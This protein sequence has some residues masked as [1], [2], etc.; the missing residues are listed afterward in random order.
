[1]L[2]RL[3][4]SLRLTIALLLGLA[5]ISIAGT[6]VP[7]EANRFEPFFQTP[8]YRLLLILLALNL[9]ACTWKTFWRNLDDYR[10]F[11]A[12]VKGRVH[13]A[14]IKC[15]GTV[16]ALQ[17]EMKR[18]GFRLR[19]IDGGLVASRKRPGRWGSTIVHLSL[20]TILFGGILSEFG[21]V[22]TLVLP[23]GEKSSTY[24]NWD[25][26]VDLP[27][28]FTV[29]LDDFTI[30]YYPI[31][32]RIGLY[33]PKTRELLADI[34]TREGEIVPLPLDG[35]SARVVRFVPFD[36]TLYLDILRHGE[37]VGS[38]RTPSAKERESLANPL[39]SKLL[40]R[41]TGFKDPIDKQYQSRVSILEGGEVV[42]SGVIEVN[43]PLVHRGVAIYQTAFNQDEFGFWSSGFQ[44]S[45]D[46][47]EPLVWVGTI[48]L[49]TGLCCAFA[50][51]YRVVAI[52]D[53]QSGL[54]LL[55]LTGFGDRHG[56]QL[57]AQF[58]Q[59]DRQEPVQQAGV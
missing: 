31:D 49:M 40:I 22:G 7:V 15:S 9:A 33:A 36:Q 27:L 21:F 43:R 41:L 24:F 42:R 4:T 5:L 59:V 51:R 25:Y 30:I 13:S 10:R 38:Y 23:V 19:E 44:L 8:W 3:F 18:A 28:D 29:Q 46:P 47:G 35:L 55:P 52:V 12:Q 56:A 48:L 58:Q 37:R 53:D 26:E 6:V 20:L 14:Q 57:L 11:A 45:S 50:L 54:W 16:G 2:Y 39:D 32:V 34:V 1:M 17:A